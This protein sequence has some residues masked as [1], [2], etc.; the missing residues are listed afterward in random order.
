MTFTT[1][2]R[3]SLICAGGIMVR[4]GSTFVK[5]AGPFSLPPSV[6]WSVTGGAPSSLLWGCS[7]GASDLPRRAPQVSQALVR[8]SPL[9]RRARGLTFRIHRGMT[10]AI[11]LDEPHPNRDGT[12]REPRAHGKAFIDKHLSP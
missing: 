11:G 8:L 6:T 12:I 3:R 10:N 5:V 1:L 7:A 9:R 4:L 2:T